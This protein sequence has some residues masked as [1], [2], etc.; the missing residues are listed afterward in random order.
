M[1]ATTNKE[2]EMKKEIKLTDRATVT[3]ILTT[4]RVL[5]IDSNIKKACCDIDV[6]A[7][8]DGKDAGGL[9]NMVRVENH[10]VASHKIGSLYMRP[11][12]AAKIQAAIDE[13]ESSDYVVAWRAKEAQAEAEAAE[14]DAHRAKMNEA[15]GY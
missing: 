14:Y 1:N 4:E 15:M 13:V 11:E 7:T 9:G 2:N 8:I 10:P 6:S 3:V 12:S 5:D